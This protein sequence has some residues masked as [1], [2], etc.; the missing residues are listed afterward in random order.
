MISLRDIDKPGYD[1]KNITE[2]YSEHCLVFARIIFISANTIALH[3]SEEDAS[4][5]VST[6]SRL[7]DGEIRQL[8][9]LQLCNPAGRRKQI[10][11]VLYIGLNL[12][13]A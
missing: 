6:S 13:W 3:P 12:A 5:S 4:L 2:Y 8:M 7:P 1:A 10:K 9:P 11:V